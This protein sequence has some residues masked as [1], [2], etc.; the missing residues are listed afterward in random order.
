MSISQR[1]FLLLIVL[2]ALERLFELVLST[3]N[4]RR[5]QAN[6]A[7]E[8]E[9][10]SAYA[11]MVVTHALFL[12]AAPVEVLFAARPFLPALGWP[13]LGLVTV[14]M[15]LR[16]WAIAT[17]GRRWNTRVLVVPGEPA[18]DSGPYRFVRHPNYVAVA[19]ELFAL[20][21]VHTAWITALVFSA[22]NV[23]LLRF[24]I[25]REEAALAA[26]A[27][28]RARLGDRARFVPLRGAAR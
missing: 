24:R 11:A 16:Y 14:A 4:A 5:A 10:R 12:V 18:V 13:M 20:P 9:P 17:L 22:A 19:L 1:L 8:G 23:V 6:G 3:R 21:L 15:A 7:I 26:H 27:D 28:Y 25:A 2:V